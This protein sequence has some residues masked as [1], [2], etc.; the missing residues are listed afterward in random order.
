M[1]DAYGRGR[2][3]VL[4]TETFAKI[5]VR[6]GGKPDTPNLLA[7]RSGPGWLIRGYVWGRNYF[8]DWEQAV[9]TE[10]LAALVP[11]DVSA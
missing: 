1:S 6:L 7:V 11:C 5:T 2:P 10:P 3:V 8:P 4:D 9:I